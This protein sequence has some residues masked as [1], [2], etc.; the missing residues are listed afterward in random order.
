MPLGNPLY[1]PGDID[2]A[3]FL[4]LPQQMPTNFVAQKD[5]NVSGHGAGGGKSKMG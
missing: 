1:P 2:C 4:L 5:T 3:G